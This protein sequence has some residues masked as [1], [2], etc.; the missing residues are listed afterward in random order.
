MLKSNNTT[1]KQLFEL[2]VNKYIIKIIK[3]KL[4]EK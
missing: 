4:K 1:S 2:N 3:H